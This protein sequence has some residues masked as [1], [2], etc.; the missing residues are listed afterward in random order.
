[1]STWQRLFTTQALISVAREY[2]CADVAEVHDLAAHMT[3]DRGL[4]THQLII[5]LPLM[6]TE[7]LLEFPWLRDLDLPPEGTPSERILA[8]AADMATEHGPRHGVS[9]GS[10]AAH[11]GQ[12]DPIADL[13]RLAPGKPI[14]AVQVDCKD[15]P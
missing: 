6:E 8:W 4:M 13:Q 2:F 15:R 9:A 3:G 5:A 11:W 1:V 14:I 7:L 12:R 10:L